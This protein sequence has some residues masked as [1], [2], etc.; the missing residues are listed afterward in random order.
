MNFTS[1][2][3]HCI[4][5]ARTIR[6]RIAFAYLKQFVSSILHQFVD[7]AS[8][9]FTIIQSKWF[10]SYLLTFEIV[11]KSM[12]SKIKNTMLMR[13]DRSDNE[14]RRKLDQKNYLVTIEDLDSQ[15]NLDKSWNE[16]W[17]NEFAKEKFLYN[18]RNFS[19]KLNRQQL[20]IHSFV[21][22]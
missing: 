2:H 15:K 21:S 5:H 1:L 14:I 10:F 6:L 20:A 11:E 4:L 12:S 13:S 16:K 7:F 22:Q 3:H 18:K 8:S 19:S 9:R 17:I